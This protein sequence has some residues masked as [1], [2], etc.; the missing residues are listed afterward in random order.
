MPVYEYEHL[1]DACEL[2]HIFDLYQRL[3]EEPLKSCQHCGKPVRKRI[4]AVS[5]NTPKTNTDIRDMGMTKLVKRDDGV[6]EN[7]TRRGD[8]SRY[9]QRGKQE[10]LPDLKKIIPD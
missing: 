8:E 6:Y 1:E 4:C 7:V 10:T 9:M 3:S 5:I 2:G